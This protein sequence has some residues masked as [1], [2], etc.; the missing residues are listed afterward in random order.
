MLKSRGMPKASSMFLRVCALLLIF[1][2]TIFA[3][4]QCST[5]RDATA[6][7]APQMRQGLRKAIPILGVPALFLFCGVFLLAARRDRSR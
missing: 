5:C 4:A 1:S 7:S 6:G 2:F 3:G